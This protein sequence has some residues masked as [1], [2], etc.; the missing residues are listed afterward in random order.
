MMLCMAKT[1]RKLWP[2]E[3]TAGRLNVPKKWLREEAQAGRIPCLIC[4]EFLR[5]NP[6]EVER[7]LLAR[8]AGEVRH[9]AK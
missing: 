5:F 8:A 1:T 7:V 3:Q 4:G 9:D 6:A 2:L